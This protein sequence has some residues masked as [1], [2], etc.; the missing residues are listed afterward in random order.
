MHNLTFK[1]D[2][3]KTLKP[4]INH[5]A[6]HN[7]SWGVNAASPEKEVWSCCMMKKKTGEVIQKIIS[8]TNFK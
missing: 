2:L 4:E 6:Y 3:T 1:P 5:Y 7:G 8:D